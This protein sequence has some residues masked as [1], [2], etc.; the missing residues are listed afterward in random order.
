MFAE[1]EKLAF[2]SEN[3]QKC[4]EKKELVEQKTSMLDS[5]MFAVI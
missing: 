2:P 3:F 4:D 1:K 5:F